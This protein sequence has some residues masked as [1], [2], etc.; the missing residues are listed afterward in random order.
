MD[1]RII[2]LKVRRGSNNERKSVIIDQ[3][4][5]VYTTDTKRLYVGNGVLSGGDVI[6]NKNHLPLNQYNSLSSVSAEVGDITSINGLVYQLT[7]LPANTLTNWI[8]LSSNTTIG[9]SSLSASQINPQT[10][11][12]GIKIENNT[13]QVNF[14]TKFFQISSNQLSINSSAIDQREISS[15]SFGDGISGGSGNPISLNIDPNY[16]YFNSGKLSFNVSLSA[17]ILDVDNTTITNTGG[18][19]GMTSL[20]NALSSELP[21]IIV[22]DYGRIIDVKSSIFDTLTG[23]DAVNPLFNGTPT[24]SISGGI[25]GLTLTRLSAISANNTTTSIVVL[26]SA[27]FLMFEGNS[28][29]R[30]GQTYGRFA[31]PIFTY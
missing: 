21:S 30:S 3:G 29:A 31:I 23:F 17:M 4:E 7:A 24:Q 18:V 6:G 12:N 10:V 14:N 20:G 27:G 11:N 26:S 25:A 22:D 16:F 13:L 5:L 19:I 1:I 15:S 9:L 8:P 28:T 2:K